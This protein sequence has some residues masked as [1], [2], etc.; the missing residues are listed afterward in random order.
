[1]VLE[2]A[3]PGVMGLTNR[4][5]LLWNTQKTSKTSRTNSSSHVRTWLLCVLSAV[6]L[7]LPIIHAFL[8]ILHHLAFEAG[9]T[10][11][12]TGKHN[13]KAQQSASA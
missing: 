10:V 13:K 2:H 7:H 6:E 9:T 12:W 1:M 3:Q 4:Q 8:C 5:T 11:L